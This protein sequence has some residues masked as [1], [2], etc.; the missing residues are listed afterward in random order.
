MVLVY[1]EKLMYLFFWIK[2]SRVI[3]VSKMVPQERIKQAVYSRQMRYNEE[4]SA[5]DYLFS[6]DMTQDHTSIVKGIITKDAYKMVSL[7]AYIVNIT[8]FVSMMFVTAVK[9]LES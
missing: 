4:R 2:V 9:Y 3:M 6:E 7:I 1:P 8:F 5:D